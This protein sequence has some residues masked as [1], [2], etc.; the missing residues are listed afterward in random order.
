MNMHMGHVSKLTS[1]LDQ[2]HAGIDITSTPPLLVQRG[3]CWTGRLLP[4]QMIVEQLPLFYQD[5]K[6]EKVF[7]WAHH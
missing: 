6:D 5:Q 2:S 1:S 4:S 7:T 3:I